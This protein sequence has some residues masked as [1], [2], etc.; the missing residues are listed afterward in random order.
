M[1][2]VQ[3]QNSLEC[4]N[5][6]QFILIKPVNDLIFSLPNFSHLVQLRKKF[7]ERQNFDSYLFLRSIRSIHVSSRAQFGVFKSFN[8]DKMI[9]CI[10]ISYVLIITVC[11]LNIIHGLLFSKGSKSA[12]AGCPSCAGSGS[13]I[14]VPVRIVEGKSPWSYQV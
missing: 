7:N 5:F 9:K 1:I 10:R 8:N 13:G 2:C 11:I 3:Y 4:L 12:R 14:A 6:P